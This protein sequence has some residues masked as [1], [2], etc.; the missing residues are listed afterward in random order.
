M[1]RAAI[2]RRVGGVRGVGRIGRRGA[3]GRVVAGLALSA[4]ELAYAPA[5]ASG[6]AFG[7][8]GTLRG[9]E[10]DTAAGFAAIFDRAEAIEVGAK[11]GPGGVLAGLSLTL[12]IRLF[13]RTTNRLVVVCFVYRVTSR[14]RVTIKAKRIIGYTIGITIFCEAATNACF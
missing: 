6:R 14:A 11:H 7:N 4:G 1:A 9:A 3:T 12:I 13:R 8:R 5:N 10:G 2:W